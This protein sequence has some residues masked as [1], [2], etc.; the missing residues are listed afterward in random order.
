ML[1]LYEL[2]R[3]ASYDSMAILCAVCDSMVVEVIIKKLHLC[4]VH[5]SM[6]LEAISTTTEIAVV[7]QSVLSFT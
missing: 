7:E 4:A 5:D 3:F 2:Y 6:V 1:E